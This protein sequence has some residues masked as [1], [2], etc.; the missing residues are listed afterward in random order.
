MALRT[1]ALSAALTSLLLAFAPAT[2]AHSGGIRLHLGFGAV[3]VDPPLI[4]HIELGYS[5]HAYRRVARR[6]YHGSRVCRLDH[7]DPVHSG[8]Y[9]R[10]D[11]H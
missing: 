5:G 8:D 4:G 3:I 6:H 7:R 1:V 2:E 10:Y 9:W 11:R